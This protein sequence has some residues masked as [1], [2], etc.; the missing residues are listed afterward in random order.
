MVRLSRKPRLKSAEADGFIPDYS[1]VDNSTATPGSFRLSSPTP[2]QPHLHSHLFLAF[3]P[4]SFLFLELSFSL[5]SVTLVSVRGVR[6]LCRSQPPL[7]I[8][9][10]TEGSKLYV[11]ERCTIYTQQFRVLCTRAYCTRICKAI[12]LQAQNS[13]TYPESSRFQ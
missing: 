2:F 3:L 1:L 8:W 7:P 13:S 12:L 11:Q 5:T 10:Y 6:T 4:L 9:T